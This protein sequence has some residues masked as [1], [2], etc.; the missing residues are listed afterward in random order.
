MAV[1]PGTL[2]KIVG[3]FGQMG[4]LKIWTGAGQNEAMGIARCCNAAVNSEARNA[5]TCCQQSL[6]R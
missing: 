5:H 4:F 6:A 3:M 1:A 2:V